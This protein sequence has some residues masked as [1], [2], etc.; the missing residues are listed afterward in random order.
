VVAS[1][2]YAW[3]QAGWDG[4]AGFELA[5]RALG[6]KVEDHE[7]DVF[8]ISPETIGMFDVVLFLGVLY[9]LRDPFGGLARAASVTRELLIVETHVDF[10]DQEREALAF[11]PGAEL[12]GDATNWFGPNV[13]AL[14]GMLQSL[15]F[16]ETTVASLEPRVSDEDWLRLT[17]DG[18]R[19]QGTRRAVVHGRRQSR[20]G[21]HADASGRSTQQPRVPDSEAQQPSSDGPQADYDAISLEN[22]ALR[23]RRD[24]L[25]VEVAQQRD[26]VQVLERELAAAHEKLNLLESMKVLRWTVWPRRIY[27][28]LRAR[29]S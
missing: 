11:Y 18:R 12:A 28:R 9:H 10:L 19:T 5:R 6:S 22:R 8:D 7:I 14:L 29:R 20:D 26:R 21:R 3:R 25:A 16:D 23:E 1:D 15:G 4:K 2:L 17:G 27:Y 24:A 13:P